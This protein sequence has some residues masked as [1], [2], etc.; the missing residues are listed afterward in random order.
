MRSRQRT[1][2]VAS[3][4]Y[5]GLTCSCRTSSITGEKY[6][7]ERMVPSGGASAGRANAARRPVSVRSR[8]PQRHA[9]LVQLGRQHAVRSPSALRVAQRRTVDGHRVA[10]VPHAAQQRVHHRFVAQK[11]VPLV[12]PQIRRDDG[13][14]AM[15]ALF[16][17]LEEGVGLFGLEIQVTELVDQQD[18]QTGQPIQQTGAW[19]GRPAL[20]TSRRTDPGR[21]RTDSGGRS[22]KPSAGVRKPVRFCPRQWARP[23]PDSR[24]WRRSRVRRKRGSA[25]G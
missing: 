4:K 10:V 2:D 20:R 12:I 23:T 9:A 17:Q 7:S 6:A 21:E 1:A 24:A 5:S 14:V 3:G 11:V 25:C 18:V 8:P 22:A 15:I 19:S 16:H 13:G